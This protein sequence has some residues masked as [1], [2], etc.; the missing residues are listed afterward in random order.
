MVDLGCNAGVTF[1]TT[2]QFV[3]EI[4]VW[5]LRE[6]SIQVDWGVCRGIEACVGWLPNT[7]SLGE[8]R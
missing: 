7:S 2:G 3:S 8:G 1:D 4:A 6:L 5:R